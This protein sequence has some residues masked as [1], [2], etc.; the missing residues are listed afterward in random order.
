MVFHIEADYCYV[1]REDISFINMQYRFIN[2]CIYLSHSMIF[3]L[4][5]KWNF[6]SVEKE[7]KK[8]FFDLNSYAY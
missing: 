2:L 7:E 1:S 8:K 5:R 6:F 4:L 3:W